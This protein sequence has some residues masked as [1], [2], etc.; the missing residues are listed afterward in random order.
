MACRVHGTPFARTQRWPRP[1]RCRRRSRPRALE[2]RLPRNWTSGHGT[3]C[4]RAS[5]NDGRSACRWRR[6]FVNWTRTS[7]RHDH[8]RSWRRW[9]RSRCW[10][11]RPRCSGLSRGR[12]GCRTLRHCRSNWRWSGYRGHGR[13]G[14]ARC[15]CGRPRMC[16]R[17]D[18]SRRRRWSWSGRRG[19]RWPYDRRGNRGFSSL[20]RRRC[21]RPWWSNRRCSAALLLAD[22]RLQHITRLG[23]V[24]QVN[25]GLDAFRFSSRG[26][27]GL[28][29]RAFARA[30]EMLADLLRFMLFRRTG[31]RLLLGHPNFGQY[32][33]NGFALDF[34]LSG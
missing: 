31:M 18:H 11:R 8:S 30:A 22:D 2:N 5:W 16:R 10:R 13:S 17:H 6:R 33:E 7:L 3:V 20:W 26:A 25:L 34:Q 27:S 19:G 21:N 28:S 12:R 15:R 23:D 1:R 32:V 14:S 24:R 4:N 29:G 9:P